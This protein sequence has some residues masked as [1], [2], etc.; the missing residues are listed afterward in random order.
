MTKYEE[1]EQFQQKITRG[2]SKMNDYV[3]KQLGN[4]RLIRILGQGGFADVYLGQHVY[5]NTLAA[6]KILQTR[7][8]QDDLE[9]FLKEARTVSNL[10]HPNIVRV[11]EF[12]VEGTTPYLVMDFA[13]N[14]TLRQRHPKGS[15]LM[16]VNVVP[17]V[18][19][20]A[21]ALQYA[22]DKKLIHRD[23]K[24]ENMLLGQNN[25]V[26]LSDFGI[27]LVSQSSR[28]QNTQEVVGTI[29]YMAPEQFHGKAVAASDQYALGIVV[30][31][32]LTG[33]RPFHGSF[34]EVA[35]QHLLA[36]PALLRQKIPEI[37]PAIEEV[38]HRAIAKDP[39]QRYLRVEAFANALEQACQPATPQ[40]PFVAKSPLPPS[41]NYGAIPPPQFSPPPPGSQVVQPSP[42]YSSMPTREGSESTFVKPQGQGSSPNYSGVLPGQYQQFSSSTSQPSKTPE[43]PRRGLSRRGVVLALAGVTGLVVVGGAAALFGLSQKGSGITTLTSTATSTTTPAAGASP[44]VGPT[45]TSSSGSN[46]DTS[47]TVDTSPTAN[48]SPTVAVTPGTTVYTADWSNGMHGWAGSPDWKVLNGVLLNDGTNGNVMAGQTITPPYQLGGILDYALETTIQVVSYNSGNYPQ[49]GFALRGSTVSNNWQG[50]AT[51]IA[52]IDA[53]NYGNICNVQITTQDYGNQL[54]KTPFDPGKGKHTYRFEAKG[55]TLRFFIDGGNVL[56][57]ADNRYLTGSLLG[58]WCYQAQLNVTSFKIIAL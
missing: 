17:Y 40:Y 50:Y 6:I 48:S 51:A 11:L 55:N 13:P 4:Y 16:P 33:D 29:A 19:Q 8:A 45:D 21:S 36:P 10:I 37:T 41:P 7:L 24:P 32:W 42:N 22:H 52:Y 38:V 5:L 35:S 44:T 39:Q 54:I 12:G 3:G 34:A 57:V 46:G 49:F 18:K 14:G 2:G 15:R 58:L 20:V 9:V 28:Y 23:I 56:E 53:K 43:Q 47:P 30:Y 31:E 27:A 25:E 1:L 26:L